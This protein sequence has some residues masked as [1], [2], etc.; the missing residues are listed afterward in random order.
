MGGVFLYLRR[1]EPQDGAQPS[2]HA[3]KAK[4]KKPKTTAAA[5]EPGETDGDEAPARAPIQRRP[6][7][8]TRPTSAASSGA[9][10]GEAAEEGSA[11]PAPAP[12]HSPPR[13]RRPNP[14]R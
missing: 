3:K 8:R 14:Q 12:T 5:S 11:R 6:A 13:R 2:A 4:K 1:A 9:D 7:A 10:D